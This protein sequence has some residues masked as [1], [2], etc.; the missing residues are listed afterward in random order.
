MRASLLAIL[1][2]AVCAVV[3]GAHAQATTCSSNAECPAG[4][5]CAPGG[6]CKKVMG[7]ACFGPGEC[8]T[9]YCTDGF[10]AQSACGGVCESAKLAGRTGFC[11]AIPYLQDPDNECPGQASCS[12][13]RSCRPYLT[14][15]T[16]AQGRAAVGSLVTGTITL[17]TL[18]SEPFSVALTSSDDSVVSVVSPVVVPAM[19]TTVTFQAVAKPVTAERSA[20]LSASL[21]GLT[22]TSSLTV[23]PAPA[24][25]SLT[26]NA[27][28]VVGGTR[29]TAVASLSGGAPPGGVSVSL[30]TASTS[31]VVPAAVSF[32]EGQ[33]SVSFGVET[34]AVG[35]TSVADVT[36]KL[37]DVERTAT[38]TLSPLELTALT[39][40]PAEIIGG[41]PRGSTATVRLNGSAPDGGFPVTLVSSSP[42]LMLPPTVTVP[43]RATTGTF[44]VTAQAPESDARVSITASAGEMRKTADVI[45]RRVAV[46]DVTV[47]APELIAGQRASGTVTLAAAAPAAVDVLLVSDNPVLTVPKAITFRPGATTASFSV[48]ANKTAVD[49]PVTVSATLFGSAKTTQIVV[50]GPR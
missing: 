37:G 1:F 47:A 9:G 6:V 24:L 26:F 12:G 13:V 16:L 44:R 11:D 20:T 34:K 18:A 35:A 4:F 19:Q 50:R 45:V 33:S 31:L 2:V 25:A 22:K 40:T 5:Q 43:V 27:A 32:A 7:M 21:L 46:A 41:D 8:A 10:C 23:V 29:G 3:S 30:S 49:I 38:I 15:L 42:T 14:G 48:V 28:T 36:A 17:S 39:L